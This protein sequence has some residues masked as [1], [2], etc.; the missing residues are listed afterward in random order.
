MLVIA[1]GIVLGFMFLALIIALA[2]YLIALALLAF[3]II[4]WA[5]AGL[6]LN[7]GFGVSLQ[8]YF[9]TPLVLG[10]LFSIAYLVKV[11]FD[12]I[13]EKEQKKRALARQ[14]ELDRIA[15]EKKEKRRQQAIKNFAKKSPV[16][17]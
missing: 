8:E 1:G 6:I 9:V 5:I 15:A 11:A 17:K 3:F 16:A 10:G 4:A 13:E 12:N 14:R 2:E 7:Q